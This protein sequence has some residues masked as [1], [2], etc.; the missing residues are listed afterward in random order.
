MDLDYTRA[1]TP[2]RRLAPRRQPFKHHLL[3][4]CCGNLSSLSNTSDGLI[5]G[6]LQLHVHGLGPGACPCFFPVSISMRL[7]SLQCTGVI[8]LHCDVRTV[9][10]GVAVLQ[11]EQWQAKE[12]GFVKQDRGRISTFKCTCLWDA[13]EQRWQVGWRCVLNKDGKLVGG[14]S[15]VDRGIVHSL[16]DTWGKLVLLG[17]FLRPPVICYMW[18]PL[19]MSCGWLGVLVSVHLVTRSMNW[20]LSTLSL[21]NKKNWVRSCHNLNLWYYVVMTY[22]INPRH[23][24]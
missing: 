20:V 12:I 24:W 22:P 10:R 5:L 4:Q 7:G 2:A 18:M 15:C 17:M 3:V 11:G 9:V 23:V 6:Y 14:V 1:L 8:F 13:I 16:T 19:V 21:K